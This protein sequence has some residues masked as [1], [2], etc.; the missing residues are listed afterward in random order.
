[1]T[2]QIEIQEFELDLEQLHRRAV[3]LTRELG[4]VNYAL[5]ESAESLRCWVLRSMRAC[6]RRRES[7]KRLTSDSRKMLGSHQSSGRSSEGLSH[8]HA[9]WALFDAL[10][11]P[12]AATL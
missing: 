10:K 9:D 2:E 8:Q 3:D 7:S 6:M 1:M 12:L 11:T 5:R 4:N